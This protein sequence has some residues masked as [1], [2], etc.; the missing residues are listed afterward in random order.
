MKINK[1]DS[2]IVAYDRCTLMNS[3][4]LDAWNNKGLNYMQA[5]KYDSALAAFDRA[6][7]IS[8]KNATVWN[9][10]G[11][12]LV[13][14]GK[15]SDAIE[16][17]KKALGINPNYAEAKANLANAMGKQQSFNISGTITPKETVSRIG[18]LFTLVA[19]T[20][21]A[22]EIITQEPQTIG[23]AVAAEVTTAPVPKKTTY[24]PISPIT[25]LGALAVVAGLIAAMKRT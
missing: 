10:K 2:A 22:T 7:I 25:V 18:T 11:V 9:N 1:T 24:S 12:A 23:E 4:S 19:T 14:L 13:A 20:K 17:F 8:I 6:T 16:C 21:Q 3:D 5:G 15:P